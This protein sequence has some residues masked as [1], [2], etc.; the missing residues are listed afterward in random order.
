M[1]FPQIDL[2]DED[3][4]YEKLLELFHPRGLACPHCADRQQVVAHRRHQVRVVVDYLCKSCRRVFNAWT[5]TPLARTRHTPSE[6]LKLIKGIHEGISTAQLASDLHC[7]RS[8]LLALRHRL[9]RW[10]VEIFG[11]VQKSR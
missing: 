6:I 3:A 9:Q 4:C 2:D 11:R 8:A 10:V 5:G 7:D 1:E